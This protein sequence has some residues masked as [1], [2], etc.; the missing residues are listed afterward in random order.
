MTAARFFQR[1]ARVALTDGRDC[2]EAGSGFVRMN[3]AL[4]RPLLL[5]ALERMQ[6]ALV[7]AR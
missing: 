7:A 6:A 2:G 4:P 3:F 1:E 5:Q